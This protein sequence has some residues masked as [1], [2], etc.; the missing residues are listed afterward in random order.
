VQVQGSIHDEVHHLPGQRRDDYI[1][2]ARWDWQQLGAF[3]RRLKSTPEGSGT[4]LDNTLVVAVSHFGVHHDIDR[5]PVVLFGNAQ[6]RLRTGRY[7]ALPSAQT[8][9][10]LLTSVAHLMGAT[11]PGIGDDPSCGPLAR[12]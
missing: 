12:L 1:R 9:D 8:N 6:G 7:L 4:M 10:K 5:I 11:I 3:V 2:A